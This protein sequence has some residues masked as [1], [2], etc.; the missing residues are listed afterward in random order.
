VDV[1]DDRHGWIEPGAYP[2]APGVWRIPAALPLDGLRAVNIYVL[3]ADGG[4]T[5]IDGGWAVEAGRDTL[6]RGLA[7]I[8]AGLGDMLTATTTQTP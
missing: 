8:G 1:S 6:V 2:A 3:V 7:E 5:L 4:L